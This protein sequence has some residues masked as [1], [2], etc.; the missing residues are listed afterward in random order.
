[1]TTIPALVLNQ[2][3]ESARGPT[4]YSHWVIPKL[5]LASAYPGEKDPNAHKLLVR[6]IIDAGV[7]VVVNIMEIE[8]LK[9]FTPYK[10]LM[11][12]F[13]KEVNREIEFISFPIRDQSVHQDD[14]HVLDFCLGLGDRIK[15]GQVILVHCWGGHGRTGTIISIMIGILFNL[16]SEEAISMNRRLHDQRIRTNG[17]SS[18][19]TQSQIDQIRS[20]LDMYHMGKKK[21]DHETKT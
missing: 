4:N 9:T 3:D 11:L 5:L 1:M 15:R 18:P 7:Q 16:N 21:I 12:Q 10:D 8:E 6:K 2:I 14:Q 19:E 20:V 13:A 17:I